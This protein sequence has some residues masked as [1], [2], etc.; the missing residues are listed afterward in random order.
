MSKKM[1]FGII[2]A[3]IGAVILIGFIL[4][5]LISAKSTVEVLVGVA[6][7]SVSAI[8]A[9]YLIAT[10]VGFFKSKKEVK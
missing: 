2:A 10:K 3:I 1:F 7:I 4:P 9:V 6:L 5:M 8:G